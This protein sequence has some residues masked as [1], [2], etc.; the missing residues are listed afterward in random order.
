MAPNFLSLGNSDAMI[1]ATDV[2][3]NTNRPWFIEVNVGQNDKVCYSAL[4]LPE[5]TVD[6]K[7]VRLNFEIMS[8]EGSIGI[9]IVGCMTDARDISTFQ[10]LD[11]IVAPTAY[12][13]FFVD[14]G[15][16]EFEGKFVA[17][18]ASSGSVDTNKNRFRLDKIN[19]V[20]LPSCGNVTNVVATTPND[21]SKINDSKSIFLRNCMQNYNFICK[22]ANKAVTL[23]KI[24]E[25]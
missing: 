15:K 7:T 18:M 8:P 24:L 3:G 20:D 11:T 5:L 25:L 4:V 16:Y 10:P 9:A 1:N 13:R 23:C 22:F 6:L 21:P 12:K 2:G 14:F 17:I 19:F